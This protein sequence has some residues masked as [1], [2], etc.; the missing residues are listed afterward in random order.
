MHKHTPLTFSSENIKII[1]CVSCMTPKTNYIYLKTSEKRISQSCFWNSS[2]SPEWVHR[3]TPDSRWN[4]NCMWP[5]LQFTRLNTYLWVS[6]TPTHNTF[7]FRGLS[8]HKPYKRDTIYPLFYKQ[9]VTF[10]YIYM[11]NAGMQVCLCEL[12]EVTH[13]HSWPTI[14]FI[15]SSFWQFWSSD[16]DLTARAFWDWTLSLCSEWKNTSYCAVYTVY[17]HIF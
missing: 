10:H 4:A 8:E 15:E 12:A 14:C 7:V 13:T 16:S 9:R 5:Y 17:C 1:F 3:W 11:Y 2:H 6:S